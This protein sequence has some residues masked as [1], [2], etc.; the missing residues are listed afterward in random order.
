MKKYTLML[1]AVLI[2][3]GALFFAG[4]APES[5]ANASVE[6][7]EFDETDVYFEYNST[8]LDLGLHLFFDAEGWEKVDVTGPNGT[9][10]SIKNG[11]A[12]RQ[13]GSTEVFT[14]SAEPALDE[15]N[16]EEEIA[17]FKAMFPEGEYRFRGRTINGDMLEGEAELTHDLPA[18]PGLIFPDPES[19]ENVADPEA[20][21]IE[22]SDAS[23]LGDPVIVRYEIVVEFEDEESEE[24]F[25]VAIQ[26]PADAEAASQS[27]TIPAEFFAGLEGRDGDYKAEVVAIEGTRNATIVEAEFELAEE[28]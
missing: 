15:E 19:E 12:L 13:L 2:G 23:G 10:F 18:A 11:G 7:I 1:T 3:V 26:V 4:S 28:E 20:T 25:V 22:W 8:D 21:V 14:E 17:A 6:V 5:Q 27:V 16:L 9:R 24:V